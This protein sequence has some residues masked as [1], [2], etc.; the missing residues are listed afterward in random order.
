VE[1]KVSSMGEKNPI[2]DTNT[3]PLKQKVSSIKKSNDK[4]QG[5]I[6]QVVGWFSSVDKVFE[7]EEESVPVQKRKAEKKLAKKKTPSSKAS[8][9][10]EKISFSEK[11]ANA[12][13][14]M[15]SISDKFKN[16]FRK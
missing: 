5:V 2:E 15:D 7:S 4:K 12:A 6:G 9:D 13:D 3:T 1:K 16:I 8:I 14:T 10:D 11:M